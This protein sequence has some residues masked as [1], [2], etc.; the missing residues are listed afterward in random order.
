MDRG[1]QEASYQ[2]STPTSISTPGVNITRRPPTQRET[3]YELIPWAVALAAMIGTTMLEIYTLVMLAGTTAI[4]LFRGWR[5]LLVTMALGAMAVLVPAAHM[6]TDGGILKFVMVGAVIFT[7]VVATSLIPGVRARIHRAGDMHWIERAIAIVTPMAA[8]VLLDILGDE[9]PFIAPLAALLR[10]DARRPR[11]TRASILGGQ[12]S[13]LDGGLGDPRAVPGGRGLHARA[14]QNP[15]TR[16]GRHYAHRRKATD[17]RPG[18]RRDHL[19]SRPLHGLR[20]RHARHQFLERPGDARCA[21]R[22]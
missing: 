6:A 20:V 11:H 19:A 4:Y 8:V 21:G 1:V 15:D 12:R 7:M 16:R 22:T 5:T 3:A 9:K 2:P 13:L 17:L 10:R 14:R 18:D